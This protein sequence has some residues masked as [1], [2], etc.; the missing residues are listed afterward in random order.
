[1]TSEPIR[2]VTFD[3]FGTVVDWRSSIIDEGERVWRA[4]GVDVDWPAFADA[5]RGLYQPSMERVRSG[6]TGFVPLDVL[7]RQNLEEVLARFGVTHLSDDDKAQLN[8]VWHRLRPWPDAISG[9]TRLKTRYIIATLSNGNIALLVNMAKRGG[10]PWD[11]ILGAEVARQYKPHPD[12]YRN[13]AAALDLPPGQCLLAAA[14]NSD[15]VAAAKVGFQRAFIA[16]PTEHGPAQSTDLEAEH[17]FEIVAEDF[18]DLADQLGC[19]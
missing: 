3:V 13:S 4:K 19:G 8:R 7:H 18:N 11:V 5:W 6:A 16:R 9:L 17:D 12:A 10:L 14:H 15:L 1:M 2:A